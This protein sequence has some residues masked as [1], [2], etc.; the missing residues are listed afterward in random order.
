MK[1]II[2]ISV[3]LCSC[4]LPVQENDLVGSYS[5]EYKYIVDSLIILKDHSYRKIL[6]LKPTGEIIYKKTDVWSYS[7]GDLLLENFP[8]RLYSKKN[9]SKEL[10]K[11]N[12]INTSFSPHVDL[13]K[14]VVLDIDRYN[15]FIKRNE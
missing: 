5:H 12:I 10:P 13:F 1:K 7:E 8:N 9:D 15:H 11:M 4:N 6:L 3:F 14:G 2:I